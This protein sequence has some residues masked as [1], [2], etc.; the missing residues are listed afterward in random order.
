MLAPLIFLLSGCASE[1][2]VLQLPTHSQDTGSE[3][4]SLIAFKQLQLFICSD[5]T[6]QPIEGA[7]L[8]LWLDDRSSTLVD[9]EHSAHN[10]EA[11]LRVP[12]AFWD[13]DLYLVAEHSE[14]LNFTLNSADIDGWLNEP[15]S[16]IEIRLQEH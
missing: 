14:Y 10:G 13:S 11:D 4:L 8:S 2:T 7:M 3:G 5:D 6:D 16:W 1:E 12:E 15:D 9:T